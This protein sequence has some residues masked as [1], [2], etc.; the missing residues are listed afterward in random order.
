MSPRFSNLKCLLLLAVAVVA[1]SS[2]QAQ[3][4]K[5]AG[6][7]ISFSSPVNSDAPSDV[8]LA[9]KSPDLSGLPDALRA[10][11]S[12]NPADIS[13]PSPVFAPPVSPAQ[14]QQFKSMLDKR[15]N[16][17]LMTPAEILG[18]ETPEKILQVSDRDTDGRQ[19]TQS[20][21]DR[22]YQRQDQPQTADEN[23]NDYKTGGQN[24]QTDADKLTP[25]G[26]RYGDLGQLL[27]RSAV[28][29]PG[30]GLLGGQN[31]DSGWSKLFDSSQ[32]AAAVSDSAQ[33]SSMSR[34]KQLLQPSPSSETTPSSGDVNSSPY[35]KR[36]YGFDPTAVNPPAASYTPLTSRIG[37]ASGLTALG[38]N[39]QDDLKP[40]APPAWAPKPAPWLSKT[41]QPFVV[42]QQK[43]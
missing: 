27:N 31:N 2:A 4:N 28:I 32:P 41:P 35:S 36:D 29:A 15:N 14:S 40:A 24:R 39:T 23:G 8:S 22:Y 42:P 11:A 20:V 1:V 43:F 21:V 3:D 30:N 17:A 25:A 33:Q 6:Q 18:V 5:V 10:P 26:S 38:A 37:T 13:E 16:W 34:F 19:K 7:P 9:P 12:F